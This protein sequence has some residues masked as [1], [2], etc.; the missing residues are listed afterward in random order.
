MA[1]FR[2]FK[3]AAAAILDFQNVE[4]LGVEWVKRVKV[5][6]R[7][8]LRGDC[9]NR[10]WDMANSGVSGTEV[11]Q[12]FTRCREDIRGV[13]A[14]LHLL[15]YPAILCGIS[16]RRRNA[17]SPISPIWRLELVAMTTS[18]KRSRNEY[19]IE[20][21]IYSQCLPTLKMWWISVW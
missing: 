17:F 1:I 20:H 9:S 11:Q 4:I 18:L 16:V 12:V 13:N 5:R 14:S 21:N 6:H 8:K 7:A 19:Q 3:M 2:F 10:C 15:C